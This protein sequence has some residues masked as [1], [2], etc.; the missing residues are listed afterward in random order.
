MIYRLIV[1]KAGPSFCGIMPDV[2]ED[3]VARPGRISDWKGMAKTPDAWQI[4][5]VDLVPHTDDYMVEIVDGLSVFASE[6]HP[7]LVEV[8]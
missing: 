6:I 5:E 4:V 7:S 8:A 2:I 1:H 3:G